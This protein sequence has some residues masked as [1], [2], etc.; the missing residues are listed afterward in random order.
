MSCAQHK[1]VYICGRKVLILHEPH[2][3]ANLKNDGSQGEYPI[4][5]ADILSR[6]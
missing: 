6:Y 4:S 5:F 1:Y 3:W 2:E